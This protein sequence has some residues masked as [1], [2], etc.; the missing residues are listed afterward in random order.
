MSFN[1]KT[2]IISGASEFA[3]A[4]NIKLPQAELDRFE[5]ETDLT[6]NTQYNTYNVGGANP[7]MLFTNVKLV[8]RDSYGVYAYTADTWKW[9]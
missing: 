6:F 4:L 2:G 9:I 8:S 3:T 1:K 7:A 5:A